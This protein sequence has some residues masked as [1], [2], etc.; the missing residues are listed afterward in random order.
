MV[1]LLVVLVILVVVYRTVILPLVVIVSAVLALGVSSA[2][3]YWL[4]DHDV[5]DLNG[6]SQGILFIL[7]L[8]AA[9]DYSLL[10]VS[11][12]RE[13]L[14][15]E[16]RRTSRCDGPTAV[17]WSRSLASGGDGDPRPAVPAAGATC[18]TCAA[19]ARSA[20]SASPGRCSRR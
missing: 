19:S 18:P 4:A 5:L 17:R 13:E 3:V 6:Q 11:R 10:I 2:A 14:R 8:G 20:R 1:A 12:F 7:A 9:T 16:G 15:D